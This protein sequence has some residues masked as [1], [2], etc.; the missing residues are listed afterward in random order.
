MAVYRTHLEGR[1]L[2]EPEVVRSAGRAETLDTNVL[3][4]KLQSGEQA[5]YVVGK[6]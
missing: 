3:V 5:R 6:A 2:L 4:G 1:Q